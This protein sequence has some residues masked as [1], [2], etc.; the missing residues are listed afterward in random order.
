M[1]NRSNFILIYQLSEFFKTPVICLFHIIGKTAGREFT[2]RQMKPQAFAADSFT[3]TRFIAAV[4]PCQVL[5]FFAIHIFLLFFLQT[6]NAFF[7]KRVEHRGI[8][9][10]NKMPVSF[11]QLHLK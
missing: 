10:L 6:G 9:N 8:L 1:K 7:K 11:H 3:R 5:N 2:R 4:A